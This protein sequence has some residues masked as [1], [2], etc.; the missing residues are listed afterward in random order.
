MSDLPSWAIAAGNNNATPP[1]GWPEGMN[2]TD[3]NDCAREIM[4][5]IARWYRNPFWHD[6]YA[7]YTVSRLS[8]TQVQIAGFDATA[9]LVAGV[10][11]RISGGATH[12]AFVDSASY[13]A[14]DTTVTLTVDAGAVV[15]VSTNKLEIMP[16]IM[17]E[18]SQRGV[19]DAGEALTP[20]SKLVSIG[21]FD[22]LVNDSVTNGDLG[23]A[24]LVDTGTLI[25][26]VPLNLHLGTAAYLDE[27]IGAGDLAAYSHIAALGELALDDRPYRKVVAIATETTDSTALSPWEP[28][29]WT[30]VLIAAADGAKYFRVS[31]VA[32]IDEGAGNNVTEVQIKV[33]ALCTASDPKIAAEASRADG[34]SDEDVFSV[35]CVVKPASGDDVTISILNGTGGG[36]RKILTTGTDGAPQA[37]LLIIEEII[38]EE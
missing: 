31:C 11:C 26:E 17:A 25:N 32:V 27:G 13:G 4:A 5:G 1:D 29:D 3:V 8:D 33:G 10:R 14:P 35:S 28:V 34:T 30:G 12:L 18:G 9:V 2:R 7:D 16:V 38:G 22:D 15:H 23:T 36:A 19:L 6:P 37:S 21:A 24:A 20:I